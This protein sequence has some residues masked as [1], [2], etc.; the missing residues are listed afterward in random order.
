MIPEYQARSSGNGGLDAARS[1]RFTQPTRPGTPERSIGE[2]FSQLANEMRSLVRDEVRLAQAELKS[3]AAGIGANA[4]K[5]GV[6]GALLHVSL[7][8]F[9]A[10]LVMLLGTFMPLWVAGL[11]VSVVYAIVGASMLK[12]GMRGLKKVS[13]TPKETI[14]TLQEDARWAKE[15][16]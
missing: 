8:T 6:G 13:L 12:G 9:T 11:I 7:L 1:D 4:G 5:V 14:R 2:L 3:N 10:A 15:Q 16:I